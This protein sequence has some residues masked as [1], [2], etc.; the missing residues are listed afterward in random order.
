MHS[1]GIF[2]YYAGATYTYTMEKA[3]KLRR[4]CTLGHSPS[5]L[6]CLEM[7][8]TMI[9]LRRC[10]TIA[11]RCR[12]LPKN[13][14]LCPSKAKVVSVPRLSILSEY[15]IQPSRRTGNHMDLQIF[16]RG[17][18]IVLLIFNHHHSESMVPPWPWLSQN[19][20][21]KLVSGILP[22]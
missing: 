12:F 7:Q 3:Y 10:E 8:V 19:K 11:I 13:E 14:S 2:I 1:Y 6:E 20:V 5:L 15:S 18:I 9:K 21:N 4:I 17:D 22:H 16:I